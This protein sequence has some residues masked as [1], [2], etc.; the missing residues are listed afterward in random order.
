MKKSGSVS[1]TIV[2]A[3]GISAR[4]QQRLDPC[5]AANFSEDACKAAVQNRGYCWNGRW[6]KLKYRSPFPYYYDAYQEFVANGGAVDPAVVG[7]C[8][9][10]AHWFLGGHGGAA[11]GGF[12]A[13]GC[14]HASATG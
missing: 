8:V 3:I 1:L 12:G 14:G 7:T 6:V 2:M 4:A 13:T 11:H 10:P 5:A 9:A